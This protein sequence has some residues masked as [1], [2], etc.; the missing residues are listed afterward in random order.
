MTRPARHT[1]QAEGLGRYVTHAASV[2]E[3]ERPRRGDVVLIREANP[4]GIL[5]GSETESEVGYGF[6][7]GGGG[8]LTY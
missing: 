8:V 2:S 3:R 1:T 6:R 5:V 7:E 4:Y